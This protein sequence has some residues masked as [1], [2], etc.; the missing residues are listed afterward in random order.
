MIVEKVSPTPYA[1]LFRANTFDYEDVRGD[2]DPALVRFGDCEDPVQALTFE[3]RRVLDAIS[4]ANASVS[5]NH[6][7]R[8]GEGI[9]SSWSQFESMGFGSMLDGSQTTDD[10]GFRGYHSTERMRNKPM[11]GRNEFDRP[12]TPSWADFLSSGF[13]D[14]ATKREGGGLLKLPPDQVL[15][16]ITPPRVQSSQSHVRHGMRSDNLDPPELNATSH[17]ELD[18]TFW[19]VWMSSLADEETDARKAVFGRCAFIETEPKVTGGGW[20]ILEEQVKGAAA[21]LKNDVQIVEKKSRFTFGRKSRQRRGS[22]GKKPP[23]PKN[24]ALKAASSPAL[25]QPKPSADQEAKMHQAAAN[26]VREQ[27]EVEDAK[28]EFSRRGRRDEGYASKT[29]S[30]MTLG[31]GSKLKDE[32]GPAMQWARK[33][34]K[35]TIRDRYLGDPNMG[36]GTGTPRAYSMASTMDLIS[37]TKPA[38]EADKPKERDLPPTPEREGKLTAPKSKFY[39]NIST[40]TLPK[41]IA[42]QTLEEPQHQEK[43]EPSP[44]VSESKHR[45]KLDEKSPLSPSDPRHLNRKP[46][47]D[48]EKAPIEQHP[49]FRKSTERKPVNGSTGQPKPAAAAAQAAMKKNSASNAPTSPTKDTENL[50]RSKVGS[51][52][53]IRNLF[54]RKKDEPDVPEALAMQRAISSKQT[55]NTLRKPRPE[56][57]QEDRPPTVPEKPTQPTPEPV[58]ETPEPPQHVAE[59]DFDGGPGPEV[60]E[61]DQEDYEEHHPEVDNTNRS[62]AHFS[63][64]TS[65]P[66]EDQPA[67]AGEDEAYYDERPSQDVEEET[68]SGSAERHFNTQT[69]QRLFGNQEQEQQP[70]REEFATP[71]EMNPNDEAEHGLAD[72]E[73]SPP[74]HIPP[75]PSKPPPIPKDLSEDRWK[76]IRQNAA[77]RRQDRTEAQSHASRASAGAATEKTMTTDDGETSGEECKHCIPI[78]PGS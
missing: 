11:S 71:M 13:G 25:T 60:E 42:S 57:R 51:T 49:A 28:S 44:R 4:S 78:E 27:Q 48:P 40:P 58:R 75:P 32:A 59:N 53:K 77:E 21:P 30:I 6:Q 72:E 36:T 62:T 46:V 41:H 17:M 7:T 61:Y 24:D 74:E 55:R 26:L 66:L 45:D 39:E 2:V 56:S 52:R 47:S 76:Q 70:T 29:N 64:F 12:T 34:D 43:R 73:P 9:D 68:G 15:P 33:Y 67:F 23:V 63:N 54:T 19:W 20:L 5:V 8:L 31:I 50:Q 38:L 3:S 1:L 37:A 69:A 14:D 22:T 18:E 10:T 16:P 35:D 65:G